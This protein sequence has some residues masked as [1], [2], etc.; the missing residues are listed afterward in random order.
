[1]V[2]IDERYYNGFEGEPEIIFI[3]S[4]NGTEYKRVGFWDGY[5]NDMLR[6]VKP[7]DEGWTGIAY[8]FHVG[9]FEK[10]QWLEDKPWH[11]SNLPSVLYQ[12]QTIKRDKIEWQE[13]INVLD[14]LIDLIKK[15]IEN[16]EEISIYRD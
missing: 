8:Y 12:L 10:E 13:T 16:N 2:E 11:I 6:E 1:M 7:T 15:A 3:I 9:M 14:L 4:N 5:F